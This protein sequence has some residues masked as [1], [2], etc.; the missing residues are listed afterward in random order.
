MSQELALVP[1]FLIQRGNKIQENILSVA[2]GVV[3][4]SLLA[5]IAIPLPWT[6]VPITGQTFGVALMALLWGKKRATATIVSYMALG[7]LGLP[8]FALG[9]AGFSV[10]PTNGYL[11]GMI[12]ASYVMGSLSDL[13]W[14]KT[15]LKAYF[16]AFTGSVITFTCGVIG[17]SFFVPSKALLMAGVIPFLAGDIVK[18]LIAS[19]IAYKAQKSANQNA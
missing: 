14:T 5:Q 6:P 16:T 1:Q 8:I 11:V 15:W 7:T 2:L 9:K 4:L 13:G 12:I 18:T 3:A 19:S 10:G 17:L